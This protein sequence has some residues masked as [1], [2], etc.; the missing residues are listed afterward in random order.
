MRR[1]GRRRKGLSKL[2][3][4]ALGIVAIIVISYMAY[5]KFANPFA[6][7]FTVHALVSNANGLRPE[8]FVRIAGINVGT[9]TDVQ[10]VASCKVNGTIKKQCQ[11][12]DVT[13]ELEDNGLPLHTNATFAIRPR[14]F[15][16]GNFFVDIKPGTPSAPVAHDGYTFSPAQTTEP[17]QVDQVLTSLQADTRHNLQLLLKQYGIA[18]KKGG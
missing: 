11:L 3:A 18:V 7:K 8:S 6:S 12:S 16:E 10:P 1:K 9:V 4:G 15:L 13:M 17:V 5:T 2:T 14:I